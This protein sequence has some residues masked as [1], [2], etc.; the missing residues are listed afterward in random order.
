MFSVITE[1]ACGWISGCDISQCTYVENNNR[2]NND[3]KKGV[4]F[5]N[6]HTEN[7]P[8]IFN[9]VV[10]ILDV[11]KLLLLF[12]L[13]DKWKGISYP[14]KTQR[15]FI[16]SAFDDPMF[17][18]EILKFEEAVLVGNVIFA[19]I[20]KHG[21]NCLFYKYGLCMFYH[22]TRYYWVDTS[23]DT[24][25]NHPCLIEQKCGVCP[26]AKLGFCAH[27]HLKFNF[28]FADVKVG[29][30][31]GTN[32]A[33]LVCSAPNPKTFAEAKFIEDESFVRFNHIGRIHYSLYTIMK[34]YNCELPTA[35]ETYANYY[36]SLNNVSPDVRKCI[37]YVHSRLKKYNIPLTFL[38]NVLDELDDYN[39][40]M[41][42]SNLE[43]ENDDLLDNNTKVLTLV[44]NNG[45]SIATVCTA[46]V[47]S[48][49]STHNNNHYA[50]AK[51][52][53]NIII[54]NKVPYCL[55]VC[56]LPPSPSHPRKQPALKDEKPLI[57]KHN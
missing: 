54:A 33:K 7:R 49:I 13:Q 22:R 31:E 48:Y 57:K 34:Y 44:K 39:Y 36:L 55:V 8:T 38:V 30:F 41:R 20:C 29:R 6:D 37:Q 18:G 52:L 14:G 3:A 51:Y 23:T 45:C 53:K 40:D 15:Y 2:C 21:E 47:Q 46:F 26:G 32:F 17:V 4:L 11:V 24:Y 56:G 50:I 12:R 35:M 16:V 25:Y 27:M 1:P 28:K 19:S 42:P 5:C 43:Y 10:K 9:S